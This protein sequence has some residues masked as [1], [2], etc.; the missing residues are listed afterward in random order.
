MKLLRA[1]FATLLALQLSGCG[2]G[3]FSVKGNFS[4]GGTQ[5][6]RIVYVD[7]DHVAS[8]WITLID[9]KFTFEGSTENP[10]ILYLFNQ[11]RKLIAHAIVKNGDK[12][13]ISGEIKK[14]YRTKVTGND[15]NEEWNNFINEFSELLETHRYRR[16][17]E[18]IDSFIDCNPENIVS[19]LLLL[20]DYSDL[21]DDEIVK[22]KL[23]KISSK[24]QPDYVMNSYYVIQTMNIEQKRQKLMTMP[25]Y[26]SRDSVENFAP[27]QHTMSLIYFWNTE[28]NSRKTDIRELKKIEE[29]HRADNFTIIDINLDTDTTRWKKAIKRDSIPWS[30]Y[31]AVGGVM[32]RQLS[33][34]QLSATP[35]YIVVDSTGTQSYS[36]QSLQEAIANVER[37]IKF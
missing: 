6:V 8:E 17:D 10:T 2:N 4:D 1:L 3:H 27:H 14:N 30:R 19:T 28:D 32:N 18:K 37:K 24:A 5:N 33:F 23:A 20:N 15:L 34:L 25:L 22:E 35:Y 31:W 12:I 29:S 26:S 21:T 36:G 13:S 7:G 16:F 11:Q 9:N